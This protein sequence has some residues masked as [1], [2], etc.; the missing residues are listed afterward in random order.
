MKNLYLDTSA[1]INLARHTNE[2][3]SVDDILRNGYHAL[4]LSI[5]H[6]L[7]FSK[8][9][10]TNDYTAF[11]LDT[12]PNVNWVMP[13]WLIWKEEVSNALNYVLSRNTIAF[14]YKY[15]T[16]FKMLI[17]TDNKYKKLEHYIRQPIKI[18]D[19]IDFFK[20]D[21]LF[22][23]NEQICKYCTEQ[24]QSI[25]ENATIWKNWEMVLRRKIHD[26]WPNATQSGL[27][28]PFDN[29]YLDKILKIAGKNS[30]LS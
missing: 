20:Q 2:W 21:D 29:S 6:L 27:N 8:G 18:S 13:P 17:R 24:V 12:L 16:L 25:R 26:N 1:I 30:G 11:Y 3:K 19:S 22:K 4:S 10:K 9:R 14:N 7:E 5:T 28:I 23:E 15:D